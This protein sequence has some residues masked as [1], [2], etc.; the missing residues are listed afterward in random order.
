MGTAV[1]QTLAQTG[2]QV[3]LLD[4]TDQAL[5]TARENIRKAVRHHRLFKKTGAGPA[6]DPEV[7][8]QRIE[9]STDYSVLKRAQVVIENVTE[10]WEIKKSVYAKVD[11]ICGPEVVFVAN[12]SAIS[13]SRIASVTRRAPQVVGMHF[14]NP[15]PLMPVVEVIPG[16]HTSPQTVATAKQLLTQMG[17][18][19]LVVRDSPGFVTNRVM[20]LAV[21]EA[22]YLVAE[23]VASAKDVDRL[24]KTCFGHKMGPLE[25]ADLI[26]LDTVLLSIEVLYESFNDSKY[27]P[28]FLL[29]KMVSAGLHGRK[30]GE[31]F[32]K[33]QQ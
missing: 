15:V 2:H 11:P 33:Y 22:I 1:A 3:L 23:G 29:K 27:R 24:F 16:H 31:G 32:Y 19:G 12:P 26:G 7:V 8:L 6:A 18:E 25:T 14:M 9:T 17:K 30:S 5:S 20:M 4:V 10:N 21:N 13:I 28:C